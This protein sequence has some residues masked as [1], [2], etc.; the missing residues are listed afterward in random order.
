MNDHYFY[1]KQWTTTVEYA[2][3]RHFQLTPFLLI[4]N[5][6]SDKS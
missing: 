2:E 6:V 5:Y 3:L 1:D 4:Y